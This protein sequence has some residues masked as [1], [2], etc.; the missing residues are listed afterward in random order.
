MNT[1][2]PAFA[3]TLDEL[4]ATFAGRR[5]F[6]TGHTGFKGGWLCLWLQQLGA[7]VAGY[8]LQPPT[9]PNLFTLAQVGDGMQ[10]TIADIRDGERLAA[11]IAA[12]RPEIVFHLAAQPLV[13]YSYDDPVGTYATNVM[14]TVHLLEALRR[15]DSVRAAVIVSSDKCYDNPSSRDSSAAFREGDP[16]GGDDPYSSS[17]GCT[18]LVVQSYR[19][20][21]FHPERYAAHGLALASARAGNVIGGGDWARDRL[22]PDLIMAFHAG[23]PAIVRNPAGVRPWQHVLE[24]LYGYLLLADRL[25]RQ[26]PAYGEGWNFG[27]ND[28]DALPVAKIAAALAA[29]WGEGASW[30]LP[31]N[32]GEVT[33]AAPHE[34][35]ILRL[36]CRKAKTRLGWRPACPLDQGL[37]RVVAWYRAYHTGADLRALCLAQIAEHE[38]AVL[39]QGRNSP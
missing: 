1:P 6:V 7:T 37:A 31:D 26:G 16:M 14:G 24:P 4:R 12:F 17:K 32:G 10:S 8:A 27:P 2:A 11:A 28:D 3:S 22:I 9:E 20:S 25:Y 15:V 39:G 33:A 35:H 13:R 18:E 21:F 30:Q 38:H 29:A 23:R 34:A 5:V 19:H 36:D